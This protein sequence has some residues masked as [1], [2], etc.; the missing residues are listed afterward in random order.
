MRPRAPE[1]KNLALELQSGGV[2]VEWFVGSIK[3]AFPCCGRLQ[4][5]GVTGSL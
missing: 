4:D 3:S 2:P 1:A 5:K